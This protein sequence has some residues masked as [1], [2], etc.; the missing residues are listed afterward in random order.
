MASIC[1]DERASFGVM[2][3]HDRKTLSLSVPGA[4]NVVDLTE[5]LAQSL[6]K[7]KPG[8]DAGSRATG[9]AAAATQKAAAKAPARK[10][11]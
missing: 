1:N 4:T 5:L 2:S 9:E 7:R 8:R 11:A 3:G 10:R 6:A